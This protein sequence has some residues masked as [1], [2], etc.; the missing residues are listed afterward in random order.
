[1]ILNIYDFHII[2]TLGQSVLT[3]IK[4]SSTIFV[5]VIQ[6]CPIGTNYLFECSD[7]LGF[8]LVQVEAH[9]QNIYDRKVRN[10]LEKIS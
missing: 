6:N 8:F 5:L 7:W 4:L 2:F 9:A 1:M 3:V 10:D